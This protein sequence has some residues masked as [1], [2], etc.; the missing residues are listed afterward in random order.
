MPGSPSAD[1]ILRLQRWIE[2]DQN[3]RLA[4]L[5]GSQAR[6]LKP[7]DAFSDIDLA[8]FARQPDLLLRESGW[9]GQFG[10]VWTRHREPNG[11][12]TGDEIR[13]L[14]EDGQDVD[15]SV[16][17]FAGTGSLLLYHLITRFVK[18]PEG[19]FLRDPEAVAVLA[20]GFR[21]LTNKDRILLPS[22]VQ[23]EAPKLPTP[24]EFA[25]A[26][27]DYWFHL[28]WTAKKLRRGE[29]L[30]ALESANGHLRALLVRT[31]RWHAIA[32]GGGAADVWHNARFFESWADPRALRE[33][34]GTVAEYDPASIA[35]ALR[36]GRDLF[37]W[38]SRELTD[39]TRMAAP[40]RDAAGLAQY[41]ERLLS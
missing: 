6:N 20:R 1:W 11:L 13:V 8:L 28:I 24:E 26:A 36:A 17:P 3:I 21:V 27:N 16:F 35:R 41:L 31:I 37:A 5:V 25:N 18:H 14:F 10:G 12:G 38:L 15:F 29:Y 4:L 33:F 23:L 39:S 34:A 7:A 40:V 2:Q 22:A 32:K 9:V 19:L 30:T